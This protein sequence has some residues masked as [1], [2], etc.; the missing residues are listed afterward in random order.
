M[1][2]PAGHVLRGW[3]SQR[4]CGRAPCAPALLC[5]EFAMAL[6]LAHVYRVELP[7][8]V[9]GAFLGFLAGRHAAHGQVWLG[10]CGGLQ[11]CEG[12]RSCAASSCALTGH[13]RVHAPICT[14]QAVLF[15]FQGFIGPSCSIVCCSHEST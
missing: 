4:W 9:S 5:T 14:M 11:W 8:W 12:P 6:F 10:G 13:A 15:L 7:P 3:A 1:P 2:A